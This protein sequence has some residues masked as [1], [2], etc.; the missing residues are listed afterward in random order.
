MFHQKKVGIMG[1]G[2]IARAMAGTI[3]KMK[4]VKCYGVASRDAARAQAFAQEFG[5]KKAFDSYEEM[6]L[7][8]KIDL[9]YIATP[10]SEH[11]SNMKLCIENGQAVLCEK[12]FTANAAQAEEIIKLSEEREIFVTEAIW[13]RYMP[14]VTTIQ[15]LLASGIIG[16]LKMLTCNLG[17]P[18]T[19]VP[20]MKDPALAGGALLDLGV[21]PINF[22]SMMFGTE[23]VDITSACSKLSTGVDASNSITLTYA[24]GKM[25]VLNSTM[26][27]PTDRRGIIYGSGGYIVV[28][29]INN[30]E[31]AVVYDKERKEIKRVQAPKQISGYEYEVFSALQAIE[32]GDPECWEMPH[33]ETLRIM[34]MMDE[35]RRTWGIRYP[36]EE[37]PTASDQTNPLAMEESQVQTY[38]M[39]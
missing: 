32:K 4:G 14:M 12:A 38:Y 31:A 1:T 9:I 2:N 8:D 15:G 6:V 34:R 16:E 19:E 17:Y 22:A 25:A 13:T 39:E 28:E 29:N 33:K 18:L 37:L 35:L 21:Y 11:Y 27:A 5:V 36:F 23:V 26:L 24:D 7:D 10:H 3:N 20:R 30:Y